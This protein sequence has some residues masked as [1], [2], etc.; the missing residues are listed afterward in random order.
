MIGTHI[1]EIGTKEFLDG[2]T[3]SPE[4]DDGGFSPTSGGV[5]IMADATRTGVLYAPADLTDKTGSLNGFII[6]TCEDS[7]TSSAKQK[8]F[9]TD[10]GFVY[11]ADSSNNLTSPQSDAGRTYAYANTDI[12]S[13]KGKVYVTS[14]T[15]IMLLSGGAALPT[16][17]ATW[18]T[19]TKTKS[20]LDSAQRHPMVVYED[21]LWIADGNLLHKWDDTTA[22][23]GFLTLPTDQSIVSLGVDPSTG[24]MLLGT[25][26]GQNASNTLP[27]G[28]KI[29]LWD[30]FSVKVRKSVYVDDLVTSFYQ[31]GGT[32]YVC[33]GRNFGYWTGNGIKFIR[34]FKRVINDADYL[35]YKSKVTNIGRILYIADG[36]DILA[37]G[38][39]LAGQNRFWVACQAS[40]ES[41]NYLRYAIFSMGNNYLGIGYGASSTAKFAVYDVTALTTGSFN[42]YSKKY[43]FPRPIYVRELH[44]EYLDA[45]AV[46]GT[47]GVVTLYDQNNNAIATP[48]LTNDGA[49]STFEITRSI[50]ANKKIRTLYMWYTNSSYSSTVAGI[51]RF[52]ISYDIAE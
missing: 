5:N 13:Y 11:Y 2:I 22:T 4:T 37:F 30:G 41:Q 21:S 24:L 36:F 29:L 27:K 23:A 17:D 46:A 6:G 8:Y 28:N 14:Q 52:I 26:L 39:T 40:V 25:S 51:R 31:L 12:V 44:I 3:S 19:T 20:A 49:S 33:Y 10:T 47:S 9:I 32:V 48:S 43:K 50:N 7:T 35:V 42:F 15:D 18:W 34:R 1:I 16:K 38:E 45:I